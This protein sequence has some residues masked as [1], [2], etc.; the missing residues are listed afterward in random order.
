MAPT[1]APYGAAPTRANGDEFDDANGR[2]A[3]RDDGDGDGDARARGGAIEGRGFRSSIVSLAVTCVAGAACVAGLA[4]ARWVLGLG[5][6]PVHAV[7]GD[8][9]FTVDVGCVRRR[10]AFWENGGEIAS[11]RIARHNLQSPE[12]FEFAHAVRMTEDAAGSESWQRK[13]TVTTDAID[14]EYGFVLVNQRGQHL[15]EIGEL[16]SPLASAFKPGVATCVQKYGDYFNRVRTMDKTPAVVNWR[17]GSCEH[18]CPPPPPPPP[19]PSNPPPPNPPPPYPP[20]PP[21]NPPPPYPPP[22]PPPPP[23]P[24]PPWVTAYHKRAG[25]GV[26]ANLASGACASERTFASADLLVE[27]AACENQCGKCD[28]CQGYV[29]HTTTNSCSFHSMASIEVLTGANWYSRHGETPV[30][31]PTPS[32]GQTDQDLG[33]SG[34]TT[35]D[36]SPCTSCTATFYAG[37]APGYSTPH[38]CEIYGT[39]G[40]PLATIT[41][42]SSHDEPQWE[43]VG[44][45]TS[46]LVIS[47]S[48]NCRVVTDAD[49]CYDFMKKGG[50]SGGGTED[51]VY[52]FPMPTGND[53][54]N[55]AYIHCASDAATMNA[56]NTACQAQPN[57]CQECQ[58][59]FYE[60]YAPGDSRGPTGAVLATI[61][62]DQITTDTSNPVWVS[63]QPGT[64]SS[65]VITGEAECRFKTN[66]D[67]TYEYARS[68]TS[69]GPG[70]SGIPGVYSYRMPSGNDVVSKAFMWC[71][72]VARSSDSE[73]NK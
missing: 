6:A 59:T 72:S 55:K 27:L 32:D 60:H 5:I 44:F 14:F 53:N 49:K 26:V 29:H 52:N 36:V 3:T 47:G 69:G 16:H 67:T 43:N 62:M 22:P 68:G 46:A 20:P 23:N 13:F 10:G 42:I 70:S 21:P 4:R 11:V 34:P 57:T 66:V 8:A 58:V 30:P 38:P 63:M 51:G 56:T 39:H 35:P 64:M 40:A 25:Y 24:P 73:P 71:A 65:A 28:D 54:I 48:D 45:G 7:K 2:R 1:R 41:T 12:F 18:Q 15:Y 37:C 17:F 9:T 61:T 50:R 31:A 19:P 33:M